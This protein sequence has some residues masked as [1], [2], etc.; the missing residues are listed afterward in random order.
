VGTA[1]APLG[2]GPRDQAHRLDRGKLGRPGR[3]SHLPGIG[4]I[5]ATTCLSKQTARDALGVIRDT[6]FMWRHVEGSKHGR[7]DIA[8][9]YRLT[10]P[11]DAL[12]RVPLLTP[13][14]ELTGKDRLRTRDARTRRLMGGDNARED[15]ASGA[16]IDESGSK[17]TGLPRL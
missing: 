7:Q 2:R 5:T 16:V 8:D 4:L 15:R 12:I 14:Y 6:G 1:L 13:E 3:H 17:N 10:I 11:A 9:E